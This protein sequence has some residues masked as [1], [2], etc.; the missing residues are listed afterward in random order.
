MPIQDKGIEYSTS[1]QKLR[2]MM[3][4]IK[5]NYNP[6]QNFQNNGVESFILIRSK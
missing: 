4:S 1:F 5:F 6:G 3:F 2:R